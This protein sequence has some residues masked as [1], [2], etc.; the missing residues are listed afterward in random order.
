M[1]KRKRTKAEREESQAFHERVVANSD[2]LR[3]LAERAQA[4]LDAQQRAAND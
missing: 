2:R 1:A 4:K 3:Q